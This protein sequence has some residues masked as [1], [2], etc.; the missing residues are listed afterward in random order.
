[1]LQDYITKLKETEPQPRSM[2]YYPTPGLYHKIKRNRTTTNKD[3]KP[4]DFD[5]ISQN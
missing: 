5:I 4:G 3:F 2:P 1:M